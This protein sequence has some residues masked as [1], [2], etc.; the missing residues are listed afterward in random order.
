ML[1]R[2]ST[3]GQE[4]KSLTRR[5][6]AK[7]VGIDGAPSI[8]PLP[9]PLSPFYAYIVQYCSLPR[10]GFLCDIT[11][12]LWKLTFTLNCDGGQRI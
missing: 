1:H 12:G 10:G 2:S 8:S 11:M 6:H 3:G 5:D 7:P 9:G 4:L